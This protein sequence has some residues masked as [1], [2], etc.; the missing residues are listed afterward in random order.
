MKLK[1][2]KKIY[3][4]CDEA[5]RAFLEGWWAGNSTGFVIG[6]G[7]LVMILKAIGKLH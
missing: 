5:R 7:A 6:A 2:P 3:N 1:P 4:V